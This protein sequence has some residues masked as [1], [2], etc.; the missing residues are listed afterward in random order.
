MPESPKLPGR[1]SEACITFAWP[2]KRR[3]DGRTGVHQQLGPGTSPFWS[4]T[5]LLKHAPLHERTHR[6]LF[7]FVIGLNF[8]VF[9]LQSNAQYPELVGGIVWSGERTVRNEGTEHGPTR[10]K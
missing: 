5:R 2:S 10:H 9:F 8:L 3:M 7:W 4:C 1:M 6:L